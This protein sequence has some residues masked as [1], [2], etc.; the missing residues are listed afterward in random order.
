MDILDMLQPR[1]GKIDVFGWWDLETISSDAGKQF[2]SVEF[3][4]YFETSQGGNFEVTSS[5]LHTIAHSLMVHAIASEA[6]IHFALK[7]TTDHI[8][9]VLPIK[10][11]IKK[12]SKP[13]TPLKL[14]KGKN[15]QY[16]AHFR[17]NVLNMSHQAQKGFRSIFVGIT[18]HQ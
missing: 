13:N 7:D 3:K 14:A 2:T 12:D 1:I 16:T 18:Q 15:L 17:K 6:Y 9:L 10:D 11:L 5:T 4:E 8:F